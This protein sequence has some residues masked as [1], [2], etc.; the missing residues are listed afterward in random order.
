LQLERYLAQALPLDEANA[1]R[2]ALE[3]SPDDLARWQEL[4]A[5]SEAFLVEHPP[6]PVW[7]SLQK[8]GGVSATRPKRVRWAGFAALASLATATLL[9]I[10]SF[11]IGEAVVDESAFIPKGSA[12]FFRAHQQTESG[13]TPV[14]AG[15]SVETGSA[16]RFEVRA[17]QP[18]FVAVLA[19]NPSTRMVSVYYPFGGTEAAAYEPNAPLLPGALQLDVEPGEEELVALYSKAPFALGPWMAAFEAQGLEL[20]DKDA[21]SFTSLTWTRR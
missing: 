10:R 4:R 20:G 18:G 12:V 14:E 17:P 11:N 8:K 15:G 2:V 1:M 3:S 13:S 9:T 6:G 7:E 16:V 21:V 5:D 19:R